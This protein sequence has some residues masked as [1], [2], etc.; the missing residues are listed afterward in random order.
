MPVRIQG[1][2]EYSVVSPDTFGQRAQFRFQ[3]T[4]VIQSLIKNPIFGK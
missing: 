1:G 2:F 4:P 3:I